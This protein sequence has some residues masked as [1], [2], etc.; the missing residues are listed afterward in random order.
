MRGVG[1]SVSQP[2]VGGGLAYRS[3]H[4]APWSCGC[5]PSMASQL[6]VLN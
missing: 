2:T 1:H 6:L 3:V 4:A 5:F